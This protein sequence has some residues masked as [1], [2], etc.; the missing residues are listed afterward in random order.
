MLP[1]SSKSLFYILQLQNWQTQKLHIQTK[2]LPPESNKFEKIYK[3]RRKNFY[4]TDEKLYYI[5]LR[6]FTLQTKKQPL[7]VH[8]QP[9]W[10]P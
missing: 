7:E 6:K 8:F 5:L 4:I 2:L 10:D 3:C 9:F 1:L